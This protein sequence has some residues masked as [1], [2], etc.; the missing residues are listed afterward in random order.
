MNEP[1]NDL[2]GEFREI[3]LSQNKVALVDN[4]DYEW[5]MQWKWCAQKLIRP[6]KVLWYAIRRNGHGTILMHRAIAFRAGIL[7]NI[8]D[9]IDHWNNNGLHNWRS[10]LRAATAKQNNQN[11]CS[12]PHSSRFKGV[13]FSKRLQKWA[14]SIK[15][16]NRKTH[17]GVFNDEQEAARCYDRAAITYFGQ[18]AKTNFPINA[19]EQP[20]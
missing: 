14:A 2:I 10:N 4:E 11:R 19:T 1:Q 20:I 13:S 9:G 17:L 7:I 5:L 6:T 3:A 16:N 8:T 12:L 18:W 15:A